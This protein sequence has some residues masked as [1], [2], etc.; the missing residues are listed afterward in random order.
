MALLNVTKKEKKMRQIQMNNKFWHVCESCGRTEFISSEIAFQQGWD[1]PGK[2]GL[3]KNLPNFGFRTV[4][5]RTCGECSI[6][7]TVWAAITLEKKP[8][9][10]LNEH[11]QIVLKRILT[12][13]DSIFNE[14]DDD[15][16]PY[17]FDLCEEEH[18]EILIVWR[19]NNENPAVQHFTQAFSLE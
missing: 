8:I 13:P 5:P 16:E 11:Q 18:E 1:Y 19:K 2:D 12:E 15:E 7:N 14:E 4:A 10:D 3:Y 9:K 6:I 17:E